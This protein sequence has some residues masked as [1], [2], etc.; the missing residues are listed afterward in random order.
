VRI[1][2]NL[3]LVFHGSHLVNYEVEYVAEL[4][5]WFSFRATDGAMDT[6]HAE[7]ILVS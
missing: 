3:P 1:L 6:T 7:Y 4:G 2:D 5:F